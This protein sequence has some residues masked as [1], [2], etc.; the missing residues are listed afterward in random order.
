MSTGQRQ[1]VKLAQAIAADPSLVLLDEPT[2]GLDPVQR[3]E[4]LA[5]IRQISAE[6]GIDVLLSSHLLEEVERICDN[7]VAL[8]A[9]RLVAQGPWRRSSATPPP[10]RPNS[11]RSSSTPAPSMRSRSGSVL[12]LDVR[13]DL[14]Q[15]RV[16]AADQQTSLDAIR[17]AVAA[18]Q[19]RL[20]RVVVDRTHSKICSRR[21]RH[22]RREIFD[23]GYRTFDGERAGVGKAVRSV[24]W[25]TIRSILG[26]GRKGRHKVFPIIVAVV[27][28]LPSIGSRPVR[29]HR[30]PDG[31]ELQP[32]YW[33]LFGLPIVAVMLFATLVAPEAIV[34]DRRDGMLRLYL[35][36]PLTAPTYLTAKFVA[37]MTSMAIVVAGPALLYLAANTIQ[38]LGPDGFANWLEVAA[39]LLLSSGIIVVFFAAVSLGAASVTDRRAFASVAVL[40]ALF[41][42]SIVVN[43]SVESIGASRNLLVLD[44]LSV[45]L[46][47]AARI[48]GDN[49]DG[50]TDFDTGEVVPTGLVYGGTALWIAAGFGVL[51]DRYRRIGAV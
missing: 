14:N 50:F 43:I 10:S 9:G 44:P 40:A 18:E 6:Y 16:T 13:R 8:D 51:A 30:R 47:T 7:I 42:V 23:R 20:R 36:T 39:K 48:F 17:D 38:G 22:D 29:A 5:L 41:G 11:S 4:M 34:R 26:L 33:E 35:S 1:R 37:V 31:G 49:S 46:E 12:R 45:P 25:H 32:E 19:A 27:A 3:D 24:A 2:D 21:H 28:F 15:L